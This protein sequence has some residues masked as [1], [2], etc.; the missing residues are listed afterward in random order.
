MSISFLPQSTG[1][2]HTYVADIFCAPSAD[3]IHCQGKSSSA[4]I[5]NPCLNTP[6]DC[7]LSDSDVKSKFVKLYGASEYSKPNPLWQFQGIFVGESFRASIL[8]VSLLNSVLTVLIACMGVY[9]LRCRQQR[10]AAIPIFCSLC[11]IP[12]LFFQ[13]GGLYP[14][15]LGMIGF[16]TFLLCLVQISATTAENA[17]PRWRLIG[18]T[19]FSTFLL[20]ATRFDYRV[21]GIISTLIFMALLVLR[22][23]R[24]LSANT[25]KPLRSFLLVIAIFLIQI[26]GGQTNSQRLSLAVGGKLELSE[27]PEQQALV[28]QEIIQDG[29]VLQRL[30]YAVTAAVYYFKDFVDMT[31]ISFP[32]YLLYPLITLIS[33]LIFITFV[34]FLRKIEYR[35]LFVQ[36]GGVLVLGAVLMPA[37][38]Q[39]G[40][41]RLRYVA[42]LILGAVLL[43]CISGK[44]QRSELVMWARVPISIAV[45]GVPVLFLIL[46]IRQQKIVW[47]ALSVPAI[48]V[49][50]TYGICHL[51]FSGYNL[52]PGA[53]E[54]G[55]ELKLK[56]L[57]T[58][59]LEKY[60]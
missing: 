3:S 14:A 45:W 40:H 42:P 39:T 21:F 4:K 36:V 37:Y 38:V 41:V 34:H 16:I 55:V 13:I 7:L 23:R 46:Q 5:G 22:N 9:L 19:V 26:P 29:G 8:R 18:I 54:S 12:A 31:E 28:A 49:I 10:R 56:N 60:V 47:E 33:L 57:L 32:R 53:V 30:R 15:S 27:L 35:S 50:T 25:L 51:F 52:E 24:T 59:R 48:V 2:A 20:S 44:K 58:D 6:M 43:S 11:L 17:T 1:G